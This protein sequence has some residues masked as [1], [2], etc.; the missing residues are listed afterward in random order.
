[1]QPIAELIAFL[2][3]RDDLRAL[4]K[5]RTMSVAFRIE[6][7]CGVVEI[8]DGD[9]RFTDD[10]ASD[11]DLSFTMNTRTFRQILAEQVSPAVA[12][13]T[14][15]IG[16]EGKLLEILWFASVLSRT[17]KSYNRERSAAT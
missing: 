2:R 1:M 16:S 8:R 6:E 5:G 17:I 11:T 13:A 3:T 15:K 7:Q 14:G 4:V 12:K 9:V 10:A